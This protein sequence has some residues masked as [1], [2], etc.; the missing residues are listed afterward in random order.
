MEIGGVE[1]GSYFGA[2]GVFPFVDF[3]L[4]DSDRHITLSKKD[5]ALLNPNTHTCPIF[6]TRRDCEITKAIYRRVPILIDQSRKDGGNPW[7][8]RFMRMFDQTNDAELFTEPSHLKKDG[9]KL[10]GNI[11]KKGKQVYLPL[12]EAKMVQ[13]YDHR[14]A[15]V[16]VTEENWMRQG[17]TEA[18]SLV[19]HQ[20][21]EFVALPRWWVS[22]EEVAKRLPEIPAGGFIGFKDIA[23][24]TNQRTMIAAAIPPSS[25]T[26]HLVLMLSDASV[27]RRLC[28]LANLDAFAYDYVV[29]QKIGGITLNF[30]IVEQLPALPPDAYAET[31]P[32]DKKQSLEKWISDRVLKLT[33]TANDMIPLADAAGFKEKVHKWKDTER[34]EIRA[35]LDAAYFHLYGI[36]RADAIYILSTFQATG[37]ADDP[38]STAALVME[39]YDELAECEVPG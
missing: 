35:E 21:P 13:A 4:E 17:Q 10:D 34:A 9:F 22:A 14:A 8:V 32:W 37:S 23:S 27:R 6:R 2:L 38:R 15:S 39:K 36:N 20:N 1:F 12:Y 31:C 26:N 11:W 24:P 7:G 25:E 33:C 29:R 5:I 28:L 3:F 30:F 18:T 16:V 19:E